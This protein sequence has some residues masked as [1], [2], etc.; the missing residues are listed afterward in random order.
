MPFIVLLVIAVGS[1]LVV[2]LGA[3]LYPTATGHPPPAAAAVGSKLGEEAGR[4]PWLRRLIRGRLDPATSTG[5]ALT[6]ALVIA[7]VGGLLSGSS[8]TSCGRAKR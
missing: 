5:L 8:P 2:K 6:L 1:G 4:H 7:V 3:S